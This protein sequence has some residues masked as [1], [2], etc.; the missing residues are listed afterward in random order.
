MFGSKAKSQA[1]EYKEKYENAQERLDLL[2]GFTGIGLW[3]AYLLGGDAANPD[4][5]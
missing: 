2:D 3:E 4:A 5:R 1:K